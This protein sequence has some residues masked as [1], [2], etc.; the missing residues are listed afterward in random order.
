MKR[1]DKPAYVYATSNG[2]RLCRDCFNASDTASPYLWQL[3]S[4]AGPPSSYGRCDR[5]T[6][7]LAEF[8]QR[9]QYRSHKHA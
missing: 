4:E 8:W 6:E 5:P 2:Y 7:T 3:M 1:C 9:Q